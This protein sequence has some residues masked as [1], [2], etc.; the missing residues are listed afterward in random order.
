[1]ST[2]TIIKRVALV[3]V[4]ALGSGVLVT[5]PAS[6]DNNAATGGTNATTAAGVLNIATEASITGDAVLAAAGAGTA[7][8]SLGLLSNSTTQTTSSLT[9][10]A[11]MRSSG[12][13]AFY[14]TGATVEKAY[15][16]EVTNATISDNTCASTC[17]KNLNATK[18]SL[19]AGDDGAAV[20][21]LNF[22]VTPNA[23]ATSA[24]V[25]MYE[26]AALAT[27]D[28]AAM[29]TAVA[30]IQ[31]GATSKGTLIQ[32]Y[33]ITVATTSLAGVYSAAESLV[34]VVAAAATAATGV[35]EAGASVIANS[36]A[37]VGYIAIDLKDAYATSLDGLGALVITGT[38][39]AGIAYAGASS[40]GTPTNVTAVSTDTSGTITVARPSAFAGKSFSTTVTVTYNGV[41]VGTKSFTF[42]GEVA[43]M[44]VTPRRIG[45]L[46]ASST[47]AFRVTYADDGGNSLIGLGTSATTV[48][49]STLTTAVT[50]AAIGTQGTTT[51]AAKGTLTCAAGTSDYLGGGTANLQLQHLNSLTGTVVKS[52]VFAVSCQGKAYTYTAGFDKA[53]YTPGSVATLTLTFKD[54]DGDLASGYDT[55]AGTTAVTF[56]GTPASAPVTAAA[57]TDKADSGAGNVGIKTYQFV[58]GSTEGTFSAVISALDINGRNSSQ[59]NQTVQYTVANPTSTVTN[60]QVLQSIVALI[61]SINK[62]I[63]ALQKLILARR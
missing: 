9:S 20:L 55:W 39:G 5:A 35:D 34:N 28:D 1:M 11:V 38:N 14:T 31:S 63:Q 52:N 6:A 49:A 47:D 2:K 26:S 13:I 57:T 16:V 25:S 45:A 37:S 15:T 24:T 50:G 32:R 27:A 30:A 8:K 53:S 17:S 43:S 18:T 19:V 58:V 4:V 44:V 33:T 60:A 40:A 41:V 61:A 59:T 62:Q 36:A 10:T 46:N 7:T 51:D 3:A 54:R 23:G 22:A 56:A 29:A 12:E 48:V 21:V 42:Q